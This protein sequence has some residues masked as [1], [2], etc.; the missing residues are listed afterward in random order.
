[1]GERFAKNS[2]WA[3]RISGTYCPEAASLGPPRRGV[4]LLT[5]AVKFLLIP[6][7][8][9]SLVVSFY[10]QRRPRNR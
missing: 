8:I 9:V 5:E 6:A 2:G 10:F 7:F 3:R 4:I 1:M